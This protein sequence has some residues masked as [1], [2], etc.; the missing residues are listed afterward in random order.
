MQ[1]IF[2]NRVLADSGL[3][4]YAL[5]DL[6]GVPE[7]PVQQDAGALALVGGMLGLLDLHD[8]LANEL[9]TCQSRAEVEQVIFHKFGIHTRQE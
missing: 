7:Q 2:R 4:A 5:T 8:A 6:E 1:P 3:R 9:D